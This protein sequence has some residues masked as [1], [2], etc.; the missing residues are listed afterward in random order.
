M[1][2]HRN[3]GRRSAGGQQNMKSNRS[4]DDPPDSRKDRSLK[5]IAEEL[6]DLLVQ[7]YEA[8]SWSPRKFLEV[9]LGAASVVG[10]GPEQC[11]TANIERALHQE[12]AEEVSLTRIDTV[13]GVYRC[14]QVAP[15]SYHWEFETGPVPVRAVELCDEL[16]IGYDEAADAVVKAEGPPPGTPWEEDE[17][18][19][20][21]VT[22]ELLERAGDAETAAD[23]SSEEKSTRACKADGPTRREEPDGFGRE[24]PGEPEAG[25]E[26]NCSTDLAPN[27]CEVNRGY[28]DPHAGRG[29]ERSKR[30]R[31]KPNREQWK[32]RGTLQQRNFLDD[33][34]EGPAERLLFLHLLA[35]ARRGTY[36]AGEGEY[37]EWVTVPAE[38]MEQEMGAPYHSTTDVWQ[39]SD[40]IEPKRGGDYVRPTNGDQGKA[41]Q[42][43]IYQDAFEQFTS[44]GKGSRRYYL[45]TEERQRTSPPSPLKTDFSTDNNNEYPF[46]MDRALRVL[47]DNTQPI[48]IGEVEQAIENLAEMEGRTAWAKKTGLQLALET[49]ERQT[50]RRQNGIAY[51]KNAYTPVFGGRVLFKKGGAQGMLGAVKAR[52]FDIEGLVNYD[53]KSCHTT[54]LK[55]VASKLSGVGVEID[56]SPWEE[57]PGKYDAADEI[58]L[59]VILVKIA[60]HAIKYGAYLPA[61]IDQA[62]KVFEESSLDPEK[63]LQLVKA[64]KKYTEEPDVA[65]GK[66]HNVFADMR[67]VVKR[68]SKALLNEYWKAHRQ[69]CGPNGYCM[70]NACGVTFRPDDF[71]KGHVRETKVMAWMLQGLEAAFVHSVTILSDETDDFSVVANE[72]D[73]LIA[74]GQIPGIHEEGCSEVVEI[75]RHMSGFYRAELVE[76]PHADEEEIEEIYGSE[77]SKEEETPFDRS[78][79]YHAER[80]IPQLTKEEYEEMRSSRPRIIS[81]AT[82]Q[83]RTSHGDATE[84]QSGKRSRHENGPS[85]S[86]S[87]G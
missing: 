69:P 32:T 21:A 71:A 35:H 45:H 31:Y 27:G 55:E 12:L 17:I 40:L 62:Q 77:E 82:E 2:N 20:P 66:L 75:A 46:L 3:D 84:Y 33:C 8:A 81:R 53:I 58:G 13:A 24:R 37:M 49:I 5:N 87:T 4:G 85:T 30:P 83:A 70:K 41:R 16:G 60:E 38:K 14:E 6:T 15:G 11:R 47:S 42:F 57:Y 39:G 7:I 64:A 80:E 19:E 74:D 36:G 65:L 44:L 78:A 9:A 50:A 51:V 29:S 59:P 61:S 23:D 10:W 28:T 34:V 22:G 18:Y 54:G 76:K 68:I 26:R 63:D 48:R 67:R 25:H 86:D 72:H 52:A 73:G 56:V 79:R 43:R 1:D